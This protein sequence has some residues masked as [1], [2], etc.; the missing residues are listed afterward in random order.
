MNITGGGGISA[1]DVIMLLFGSDYSGGN[2]DTGAGINYLAA[3]TTA[4][5]NGDVPS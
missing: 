4:S 1:N 5:S 2:T 3:S